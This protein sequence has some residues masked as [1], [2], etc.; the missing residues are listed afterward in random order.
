MKLQEQTSSKIQL[1]RP[2]LA[3]LRGYIKTICS[4][5]FLLFFHPTDDKLIYV[6]INVLGKS[7]FGSVVSII[8]D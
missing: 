2:W 6:I 1:A 4:L 5:I 3:D 7:F 8:L